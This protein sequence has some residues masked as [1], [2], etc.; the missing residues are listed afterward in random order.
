HVE[1]GHLTPA[2]VAAAL[3][4]LPGLVFFDS[5]KESAAA[6]ISVVAAGP[7]ETIIGHIA[8]DW[9]RLRSALGARILSDPPDV[10]LPLGF[11][12]GAVEY[13]GSFRFNFYDELLFYLHRSGEW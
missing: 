7:S 4:H 3:Q 8:H 10:D 2:E 11:A 12:A 13:D 6:A 5:A 9:D 1:L